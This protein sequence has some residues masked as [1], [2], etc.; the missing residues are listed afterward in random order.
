VENKIIEVGKKRKKKGKCLEAS[1]GEQDNRGG[2]K[3]K[4][5]KRKKKGKCLEV[6]GG[7]QK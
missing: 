5:G 1:G 6:S 3:K 4:K 2:E 7:E